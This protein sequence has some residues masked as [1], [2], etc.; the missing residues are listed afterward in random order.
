MPS[1]GQRHSPGSEGHVRQP[2]HAAVL[3]KDLAGQR[4]EMPHKYSVAP[5]RLLEDSALAWQTMEGTRRR[6]LTFLLDGL[7]TGYSNFSSVL[8]VPFG[9]VKLDRI[10]GFY[11]A[12]SMPESELAE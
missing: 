11:Y 9:A 8:G 7:G 12:C 1:V 10:Q 4:E 2:A 6:H 3:R 5:E